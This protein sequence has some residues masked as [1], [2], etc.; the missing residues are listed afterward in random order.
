MEALDIGGIYLVEESMRVYPNRNLAS[1]T[2]GFVNM[3]G[4]GG[5]GI[6]L[7]NDSELKGTPGQVSFNVDARRR[8]FRGKVER[9]PVQGQSFVLSL[10]RS[11]QYVAE[12]ELAA[13]VEKYHAA[14][15]VAVDAG[16][17]VG[18][19]AAACVGADAGVAAGSAVATR[20]P[21]APLHA[22]P[23]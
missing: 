9:A 3:N 10:D 14:A 13:A 20:W 1:N 8:V 5:G 23:T 6:E 11:I 21:R 22:S 17:G 4:D 16:T 2:L 12:R 18:E 15:G 19:R 7:Q